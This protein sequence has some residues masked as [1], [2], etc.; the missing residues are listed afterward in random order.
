MTLLPCLLIP[1]RIVKM[2]SSMSRKLSR[3]ILLKMALL[4][5]SWERVLLGWEVRLV[6]VSLW[7]SFMFRIRS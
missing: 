2:F 4:M 7:S 1:I 6:E 3:F 5:S